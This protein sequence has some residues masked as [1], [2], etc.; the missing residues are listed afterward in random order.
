MIFDLIF[1]LIAIGA[2]FNGY[3]NGLITTILR[4]AFFIAGGV[5]AMHFVVQQDQSGWLIVAIIA[6]AYAAAWVGTQIAKAL[7]ITLIRGPLRFIDSVL[8]AILEVGKYVL[9]FYVI[10][11]ILLWAPWSAG[12]NAVSES[13]FYLQVDKH[14]P[15]VFADIRREVEK[16]LINPRL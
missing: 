5:A 15:G 16:A 9:L 7:K 13:E 10:G 12:Q 6:G 4:T 11:T 3:K 1:G 8:G 14:A 2:L